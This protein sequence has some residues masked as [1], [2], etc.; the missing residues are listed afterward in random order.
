MSGADVQARDILMMTPLHWA[1]ERG[2]VHAME[3]LLKHGAMVDAE[4]KFDKTPGDISDDNG[5][6]DL[7]EVILNAAN[8]RPPEINAD[9]ELNSR[10]QTLQSLCQDVGL[11]VG[12]PDD[13][14]SS[15][16]NKDSLA[17]TKDT[18]LSFTDNKDALSRLTLDLDPVQMALSSAGEVVNTASNSLQD[19]SPQDLINSLPDLGSG[20]GSQDDALKLLEAHG[21]RM[22]PEDDLNLSQSLSLTEAGKLVLSSLSPRP[23]ALSSLSPRPTALNTPKPAAVQLVKQP[24]TVTTFHRPVTISSSS[25]RPHRTEEKTICLEN[26]I[27]VSSPVARVSPL[28]TLRSI[29]LPNSRITTITSTRPQSQI[30]RNS[31]SKV[32]TLSSNP[33]KSLAKPTPVVNSPIT[34]T[35]QPRVIKLTPEQFAALKAGKSGKLI[36]T[37]PASSSGG[38]KRETI[39]LD[40]TPR[41]V[42]RLDEIAELKKK[43]ETE[44]KEAERLR[45]EVRKR[46]DTANRIRKQIE[47]LSNQ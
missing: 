32:V 34:N 9:L 28:N 17:F 30:V 4:S 18:T 41:K 19:P 35:K 22:L 13:L 27:S 31:I 33:V 5:R 47:I 12:D 21:I 45:L 39:T 36:L 43:L 44:L 37:N 11:T 1:V 7:K 38:I 3:V 14:A 23:T 15:F 40:T 20:V 46:E 6:P 16:T 24:P 2:N 10:L 8:Y 25:S 29:S 26:K 42:Q